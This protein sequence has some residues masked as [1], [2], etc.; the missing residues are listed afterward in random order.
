MSN[1][2]SLSRFS[3]AAMLM[4]SAFM[5]PTSAASAPLLA[6]TYDVDL[7]SASTGGGNLA[8]R[9]FAPANAAA[10]RYPEG[11]PVII[12][13]EG[14]F[15]AGNLNQQ[16]AI[17]S[18]MVRIVFLFPGGTDL[19]TMR[20]SDGVYD[21]RGP[22]SMAA[23]RDVI[24]YAGGVLTD[25]T[26]QTIDQRTGLT[27]LHDNIG[28]L[29][30]SNGGNAVMSVAAHYGA[31]LAGHLKYIVQWESPVGSQVSANDIGPTLLPCT[32]FNQYGWQVVN[33]RY[34]AYA[35]Y[36]LTVDYTQ[37]H[38]NP[39]SLATPIFF[40]GNN[41]GLYNTVTITP[42]G[43]FT[44]QSPDVNGNNIP[45]PNEDFPAGNQVDQFGKL[46][47]SVA[48]TQALLTYNVITGTWPAN[49]ATLTETVDFYEWRD[50]TRLYDDALTNLP[51]LEGMVL[52]SV[53]D[54][55]QVTNDKAHIHLAFDGWNDTGAWVQ[56]NPSPTYI[57][58]TG[59]TNTAGLPDN[60]PNTPPADWTVFDYAMPENVSSNALQSAGPWQMA[61]RAR[62]A[63]SI[64][65]LFLPIVT[66]NPGA[67]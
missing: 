21:Y 53:D 64:F 31:Q 45:D 4:V 41:D 63:A 44:C 5:F 7:P 36:T 2:R 18:D 28:I 10:A 24:L 37:L 22:N 13:V 54:H 19:T 9:I 25:T 46:Y 3:F 35:P 26:G 67:P 1:F 32:G 33:P 62:A 60:L 38:Y 58:S 14:G 47:Y 34:Q 52:A 29:G 51:T 59:V 11:A 16:L 40:D 43:T 23:L 6:I 65:P 42:T 49:I 61:D 30:N 56:I 20:S 12:Y 66:R 48:A 55:V 8:L 15:E 50:A 27:V 39:V 17:A 57:I